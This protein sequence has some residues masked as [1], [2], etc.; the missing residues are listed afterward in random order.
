[1]F[2]VTVLQVKGGTMAK[3]EKINLFVGLI[4]SIP[5][6]LGMIAW[7]TGLFRSLASDIQF[8]IIA[9]FLLVLLLLHFYTLWI[10]YRLA[11]PYKPPLVRSHTEP[12]TYISL[13]G[14]WRQIPDPETRDYL[15]HL[16]GFRPGK[17]DVTLKPK[18]EV[19]KLRKGPPLE[20]IFTYARR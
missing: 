12:A 11:S 16:L 18:N 17:E 8:L 3:L 20:S 19:D 13:H 7:A 5:I 15:A 4:T 14:Q 10:V 2:V 1:M 9:V 6:V